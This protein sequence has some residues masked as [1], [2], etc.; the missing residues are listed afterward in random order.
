MEKS[1]TQI[2]EG[3]CDRFCKEYCKYKDA[4]EKAVYFFYLQRCG[5]DLPKEYAGL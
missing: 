5:C 2:I 3:A 1:I 4:F